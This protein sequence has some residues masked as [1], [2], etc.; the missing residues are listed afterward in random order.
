[1]KLSQAFNAD[2]YQ[3]VVASSPAN[4]ATLNH[5]RRK[6]AEHRLQQHHGLSWGTSETLSCVPDKAMVCMGGFLLFLYFQCLLC[7]WRKQKGCHPKAARY[8]S[9]CSAVCYKIGRRVTKASRRWKFA[10]DRKMFH[11]KL[12]LIVLY[13]L[14][15]GKIYRT[16]VRWK[17][18][19]SLILT[20]SLLVY[21]KVTFRVYHHLPSLRVS[22]WVIFLWLFMSGDVELNPGPKEGESVLIAWETWTCSPLII[23][24]AVLRQSVALP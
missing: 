24:I 1:M 5:Q 2:V 9:R 3:A 22:A 10:L 13:Y 21:M 18:K 8:A 11:I 14:L 17:T 16:K 7:K 6:V 15:A 19:V 20:R 12:W 23:L 4:R